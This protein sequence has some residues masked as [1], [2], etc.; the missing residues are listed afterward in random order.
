MIFEFFKRKKFVQIALKKSVSR[1][2]YDTFS[3]KKDGQITEDIDKKYNLINSGILVVSKK[4]LPYLEKK[5]SLEKKVFKKLIKI[6]KFLKE[7]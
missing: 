4:I 2:R 6:K 3:L 5:G 7:I 1:K